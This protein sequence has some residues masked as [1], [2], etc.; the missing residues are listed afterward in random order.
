MILFVFYLPS[1]NRYLMNWLSVNTSKKIERKRLKVHPCCSLISV[2]KY[3]KSSHLPYCRALVLVSSYR[4]LIAYIVLVWQM[5]SYSLIS[6][7]STLWLQITPKLS[8]LSTY[9]NPS[10]YIVLFLFAALYEINQL[11]LNYA[12]YAMRS[13]FSSFL[14]QAS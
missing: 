13:M 8:I 9:L 2:G 3:S 10:V 4:P 6:L 14:C 7:S 5:F 12:A 1:T 11:H